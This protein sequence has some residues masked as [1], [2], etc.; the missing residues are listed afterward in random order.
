[1]IYQLKL[2]KFPMAM[3]KDGVT[4]CHALGY[5]FANRGFTYLVSETGE[6]TV[7]HG[8]KTLVDEQGKWQ[9]E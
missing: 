3:C 2:L 4:P 8:V 9:G 5:R 1:M 6:L 7:K